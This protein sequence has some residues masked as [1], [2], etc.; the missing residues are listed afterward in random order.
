MRK[1]SRRKNPPYFNPVAQIL[2]TACWIVL[3]LS[4]VIPT[5]LLGGLVLYTWLT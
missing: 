2:G 4:S 5:L 1:T 3:I